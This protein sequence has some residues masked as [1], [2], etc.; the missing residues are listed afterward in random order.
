MVLPTP[1]DVYKDLLDSGVDSAAKPA[2]TT[3]AGLH[4]AYI[5]SYT[6]AY[7]AISGSFPSSEQSKMESLQKTVTTLSNTTGIGVKKDAE[8]A[9]DVDYATSTITT[10]PIPGLAFVDKKKGCSITSSSINASDDGT[11]SEFSGAVGVSDYLG[12]PLGY[13]A[14][15]ASVMQV[16]NLCQRM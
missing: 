9:A 15:K 8:V 11:A 6:S 2:Y 16:M 10:C 1:I 13:S 3:G 14:M 12:R 4:L 5:G 7:T